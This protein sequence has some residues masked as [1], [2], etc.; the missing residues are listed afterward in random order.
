MIIRS[1]SDI[2]F[3]YPNTPNN[4]MQHRK[5]WHLYSNQKDTANT[6][7]NF[8]FQ[9]FLSPIALFVIISL[10]DP[11]SLIWFDNPGTSRFELG[12]TLL[13]LSQCP[14]QRFRTGDFP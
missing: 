8:Y 4:C 7:S 5:T 9:A 6:S 11:R 14:I 1:F 13:F 2:L 12:N 10:I 3:S